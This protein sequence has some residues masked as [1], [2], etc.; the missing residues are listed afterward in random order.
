M[1]IFVVAKFTLLR[2]LGEIHFS[3]QRFARVQLCLLFFG[4]GILEP[5][6]D[7][8]LGQSDLVAQQLTL[9]HC[10]SLVVLE[11]VFHDLHL[12]RNMTGLQT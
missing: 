8:T 6:L 9:C 4:P 12:K 3:T 5:H 10:W 11:Q 1:C 7:H 2:G